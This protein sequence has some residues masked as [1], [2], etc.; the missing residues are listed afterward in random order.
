MVAAQEGRDK[1]HTIRA[2]RELVK[3]D[4]MEKD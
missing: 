1:K 4:I 3:D 2:D